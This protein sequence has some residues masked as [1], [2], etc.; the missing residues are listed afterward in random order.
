MKTPTYDQ[1]FNPILQAL[2]L[3]GGSTG[4]GELEDKVAEILNLSEEE[5]TEMHSESRTKFSYNLAWARYYLKTARLINNSQRGIWSLTSQGWT[6]TKIDAKE[7]KKVVKNKKNFD[8]IDNGSTSE[9]VKVA[10]FKGAM[11]AR[12]E[13]G[14]IITTGTFTKE[15]KKEATRDAT[16]I[17]LVDGELLVD[18]MKELNLGVK[19]R[20]EEIVDVD[21]EWFKNF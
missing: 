10:K 3:L 12:A 21:Q 19:I 11:T 9:T 17:D 6:K 5:L 18:K 20:T 4:V 15:A 7:V 8:L 2:H 1:L 13:K 16:S 14:L